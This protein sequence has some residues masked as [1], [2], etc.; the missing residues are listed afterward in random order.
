[1]TEQ[2]IR[3]AVRKM[4]HEKTGQKKEKITTRGGG[5]RYKKSIEQQGALARTNPQELMRRLKISRVNEKEDIKRL[6]SLFDQA[7]SGT[8][9]MKAVYGEPSPRKDNKSG[10]Q[11][12]RIPITLIPERDARKYLEHTLVGALG[13]GVVKFNEDLQVEI[14]GSDILVY[15]SSRPLSWGHAPRKR[16]KQKPQTSTKPGATKTPNPTDVSQPT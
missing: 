11:G 4:L 15:F 9:A 6:K 2:T 14:L 16:K 8:E 13:A 7:V 12:V 5:G 1:M 10:M 3:H